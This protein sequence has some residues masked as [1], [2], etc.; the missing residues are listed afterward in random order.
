[1]S[2]FRL[3]A[4]AFAVVA[5]ATAALAQQPLTPAPAGAPPPAGLDEC[6]GCHGLAKAA[7]PSIGPNLWGVGGRKAGAGPGFEYSPAMTA[8]G[9]IWTAETL[10][11]FV[12]NPIGTVPG[13]IMAYPGQPDPA[14]SR[15]IAAYLMTLKD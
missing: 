4:L 15:A 7:P 5:G 11:P 12:V 13:T 6:A 9:A 10:Q 2:I 3:F 14:I 8:Y 1:M